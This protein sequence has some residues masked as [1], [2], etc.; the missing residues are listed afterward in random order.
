MAV[1]KPGNLVHCR[2]EVMF[3]LGLDSVT[4]YHVCIKYWPELDLEEKVWVIVLAVAWQ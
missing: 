3:I 2:L 4:F 1:L